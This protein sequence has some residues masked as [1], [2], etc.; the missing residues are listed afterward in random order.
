MPC[1]FAHLA[2]T[3][4]LPQ[5][6]QAGTFP[7]DGVKLPNGTKY[8]YSLWDSR[9][10]VGAASNAR[11]L[12]CSP[13]ALGIHPRT[14]RAISSRTSLCH[15]TLTTMTLATS[16]RSWCAGSAWLRMTDTTGFTT[17]AGMAGQ[18]ARDLQGSAPAVPSMVRASTTARAL[19]P[20]SA[21]CVGHP[22]D[23]SVNCV[24]GAHISCGR[25]KRLRW[26][27]RPSSLRAR[28]HCRRCRSC[29]LYSSV[30]NSVLLQCELLRP[31]Q[32]AGSVQG[33]SE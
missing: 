22:T 30:C 27:W 28:M 29:S 6:L 31:F 23:L 25:T 13:R 2:L 7:Y 1:A 17:S 15:W 32:I 4:A 11:A 26:R 33:I 10:Q 24:A 9:I 19:R 21:P 3:E 12:S 8:P 14:Y 18:S 5:H 20:E 16:T